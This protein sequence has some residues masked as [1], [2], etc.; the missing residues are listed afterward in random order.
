VTGGGSEVGDAG[1]Q[2]MVAALLALVDA[3]SLQRLSKADEF[4]VFHLQ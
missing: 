1:A 3:A 4:G 2:D